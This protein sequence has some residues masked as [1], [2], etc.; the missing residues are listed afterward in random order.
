MKNNLSFEH[1]K[2]R[3]LA[4]M[5]RKGMWRSLYAPPCHLF[6]WKMGLN[7]APPPFSSFWNNFFCFTSVNTPFWGMVMWFVFW[8]GESEHL[9]SA[10]VAIIAFGAV[11]GLIVSALEV[12][13][14]KANHLPAWSAV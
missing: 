2:N 7:V 5:S 8:K 11:A 10:L 9:F 3:A 4:I 12:W 6:L 1:K 13:R 14:G